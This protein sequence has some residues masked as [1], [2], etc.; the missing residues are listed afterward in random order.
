MIDAFG[1]LFLFASCY[2]KYRIIA[3]LAGLV[4]RCARKVFIWLQL[5]YCKMGLI[6]TLPNFF[7]KI[8]ADSCWAFDNKLRSKLFKVKC[9]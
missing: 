4:L 9:D 5:V 3:L 7:R 8:G 2:F 1:L 6:G